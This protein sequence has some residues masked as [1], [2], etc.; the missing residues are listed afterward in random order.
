MCDK[1]LR[2]LKAP[3]PRGIPSQLI[4]KWLTKV[5]TNSDRLDEKLYI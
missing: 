5:G 2:K 4:N 1:Q 3:G